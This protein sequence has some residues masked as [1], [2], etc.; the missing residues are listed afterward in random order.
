MPVKSL[1][2]DCHVKHTPCTPLSC[3]HV[4]VRAYYTRT[5]KRDKYNNV[6]GLPE[7]FA[8]KLFASTH[9]VLDIRV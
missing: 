5:G 7:F 2:P 8:L 1:A 9:V 4:Y 3:I 6:M